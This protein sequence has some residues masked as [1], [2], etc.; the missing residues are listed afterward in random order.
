MEELLAGLIKLIGKILFEI[1]FIYTGE[2]LFYLLTFGKRKP[3]WNLYADE[4]ASKFVIFTEISYDS[5]FQ[6]DL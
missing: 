5:N 4:T 2:I 1:P 3:R 6:L